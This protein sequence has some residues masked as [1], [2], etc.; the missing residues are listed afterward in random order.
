VSISQR[1]LNVAT[2]VGL[3]RSGL[4]GVG[5]LA[6]LVWTLVPL[7]ALVMVSIVDREELIT[8]PG[9]LY[10][11]APNLRQYFSLLQVHFFPAGGGLI[12]SAGYNALPLEGWLNSALVAAAVVPLTLAISLPAAYAFS[13]LRF[14]FRNWLLAGLVLT[15]AYPPVSVLIPFDYF[16]TRIG[17]TGGLLGL[18]IA[19]LTLTVPLITWVMSGFFG[20]LPP[21]LERAAR[22]DGLTRLQALVRVVVPLSLHGF[23]AATVIA[24][25]TTWNEF[26]FALILTNGSHSQTAPLNVAYAGAP[27]IVLSILPALVLALWFQR[28][29]RSLNIID[30]L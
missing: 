17:L 2:P 21:N 25:I 24:F 1:R 22:I 30:P 18:V 29:I 10:P 4:L 3:V 27:Y 6:L 8:R 28:S 19:H 20:A 16:F 7:Y 23:A 11:H 12:E 14:R 15:R 9:N 26:F 5:A 13:R